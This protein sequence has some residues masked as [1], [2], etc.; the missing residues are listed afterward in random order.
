MIRFHQRHHASTGVAVERVREVVE[1]LQTAGAPHDMGEHGS[2]LTT[3][4]DAI[5]KTYLG[6]QAKKAA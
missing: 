3:A 4:A 1:I 5:S 2:I 6:G